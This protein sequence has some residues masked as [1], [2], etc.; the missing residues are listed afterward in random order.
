MKRTSAQNARLYGLLQQLGLLSDEDRMN[1]ASQYSGGRTQQTSELSAQECAALIAAL[2]KHAQAV[3][4]QRPAVLSRRRMI[5]KCLHH[6]TKAGL[7]PAAPGRR[8]EKQEYAQ[9]NAW[10]I[11]YS[12]HHKPLWAYTQA[13]L[14]GLV[15]QLEQVADWRHGKAVDA[16]LAAM[17]EEAGI[18][19]AKSTRHE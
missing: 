3:Q 18:S 14:P 4:H 19:R 2:E 17:L 9:F 13:E 1:L 11:K 5:S 16:E 6:A 12:C 8:L 7:L 10:M 15:S